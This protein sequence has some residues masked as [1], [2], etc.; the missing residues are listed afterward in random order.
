MPLACPDCGG[1][2]DA[3]DGSGEPATLPEVPGYVLHEESARGGMGVVFRGT[4]RKT[5]RPV[6][7]KF[8]PPEKVR[9]ADS[10]R[11][12]ERE[13]EALAALNH[14]GI[15]RFLERLELGDRQVL[16][17]EWVEGEP[18][19][20]RISSGRLAPRE[21]FAIALELLDT[22]AH[23]HARGVIHRDIKPQNILLT[24][25]GSVKLTDFGLA[26]LD[27]GEFR[28]RARI[29]RSQSNLGSADY[30]APEQR[31]DSS[32][33]DHRADL[34]SAGVVLYEMLT[35]ELPVGRFSPPST[36][37]VRCSPSV[38]A[39]VLRALEA[40]PERRF[41]S[42]PRMR[43]ALAAASG[44]GL[45]T[46]EALDS[47]DD[48]APPMV[49]VPGGE[50]RMGDPLAG[51]EH[52]VTLA[53]YLIDAFPVTNGQYRRFVESTGHPEPR[54]W[55][56]AGQTAVETHPRLPVVGVSWHD[57]L[58]YAR[59]A[60]K[61]LPSEAEWEKAARGTDGRR[62]PWGDAPEPARCNCRE[63]GT[64]RLTASG[65]R[66]EGASPYGA[67]DMLGNVL[68]WTSSLDGPY[69]YT[70]SDGRENPE[71]RGKRVLRGGSWYS[72]FAE[73][74]VWNRYPELA[75]LRMPNVG[76][77]CARTHEPE[78]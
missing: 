41:E 55:L 7:L 2:L 59:W 76:F 35:G 69:P 46:P 6:A 20:R 54:Y 53:P 5:G 23:A 29:T 10:V 49:F 70:P 21:I 1:R 37:P 32:R 27:G 45:K 22:L 60:G 67:E 78:N 4:H 58:A 12:F 30:M 26:H 71:L 16:V 42:A 47:S 8:L 40:D 24:L 72:P 51:A 77:R 28:R 50:F 63:S 13:A 34:Y 31:R 33:V 3:T 18:L 17:M 19:D 68:E 44:V 15:V 75:D 38:D 11:R 57:A 64:G 48:A 36:R 62:Y 25:G 39:V 14:P 73:L 65:G 61:R 43:D 74:A 56:D 9:D 66:S 52:T